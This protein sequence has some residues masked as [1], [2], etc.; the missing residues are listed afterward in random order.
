MAALALADEEPEL[1]GEI[2]E[3]AIESI[4]R[5]MAAYA[6]DGAWPEGPGYWNCGMR[7]GF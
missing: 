1:A 4:R 3:A 5:P 7:Y 2:L 6:P